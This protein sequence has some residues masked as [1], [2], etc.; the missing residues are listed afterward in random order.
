M[1]QVSSTNVISTILRHDAKVTSY[2]IALIRAINDVVLAFP[3]LGQPHQPVL[4]PLRVLAEFWIAYYWPFVDPNRPIWQGPRS[5]RSYGVTNDMAFRPALTR[6]RRA[7]EEEWGLTSSPADGYIVMN[8]MRV[9]RKRAE[10][11]A[12]LRNAYQRAIKSISATVQM[13]VRYAG[14][15]QWTVFSQPVRYDPRRP[16]GTPMPGTVP[17][18]RCLQISAEIWHLFRDLSLW[19]EALS[20]HRWSLFAE[21]VDQS[22]TEHVDRGDV[23]RLLT[24]RPHN[25]RPLTWERNQI[26]LLIMEGQEFACPW[27]QKPIGRATSYDID[28]LVPVSVYPLNEVW[29]LVPSDRYFNQHVKRDRLPDS[30]NLLRAGPILA[31]TYTKYTMPEALAQALL[32]DVGLRFAEVGSNTDR[33]AADLAEAVVGFLDQIAVSR[34]VARF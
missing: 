3:G 28:H 14:S 24:T 12:R 27:T 31:D 19:V 17:G 26:D 9:P 5:K 11:S 25:R 33:F 20:I 6:L 22:D 16:G 4:V 13:P 10:H 29:N 8:E 1:G 23:Y 21:G 30:E 2:K 32:E 15:G 34:N 18:E 7:W